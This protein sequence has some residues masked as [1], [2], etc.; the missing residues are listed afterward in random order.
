MTGEELVDTGSGGGS[1][2]ALACRGI[3]ERKIMVY[4]LSL[5]DLVSGE[6]RVS[7]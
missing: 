7:R 1:G 4:Q 3:G 5:T 6:E 2:V